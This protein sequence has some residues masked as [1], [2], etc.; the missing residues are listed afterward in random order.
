MPIS[1]AP[2]HRRVGGHVT[3]AE[4]GEPLLDG[5]LLD[6]LPRLGDVLAVAGQE[7]GAD[8]VGAGRRERE[9]ERLGLVA[10][11]PVGDAEQDARAVTRVGL[12]PGGTTVL[13]VAQRRDRLLDD[14]VAGNAGQGG[15]EGDTARVVLVSSVVQA[16]GRRECMHGALSRRRGT[17]AREGP[18]R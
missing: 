17:A 18:V 16:L 4:D 8:G 10:E 13:E 1:L 3:P 11:E 2:A 5:E 15:D 9:A 14:V 12:G 6:A 7:R